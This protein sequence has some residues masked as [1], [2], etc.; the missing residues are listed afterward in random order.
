METS[1]MLIK[2][3][4]PSGKWHLLTSYCTV[5]SSKEKKEVGETNIL[6]FI[7]AKLVLECN[8]KKQLA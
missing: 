8:H 3:G 6:H 2:H 7:L 5:H 4:L 1:N